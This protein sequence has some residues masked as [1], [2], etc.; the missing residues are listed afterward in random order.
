[1]FSPGIRD[2]HRYT[3]PQEHHSVQPVCEAG[4]ERSSSIMGGCLHR[5]VRHDVAYR[6]RHWHQCDGGSSSGWST[7]PGHPGGACRRD[8]YLHHLSRDPPT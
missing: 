7:H 4:P 6:N 1:M 2:L 8:V 5:S 3:C